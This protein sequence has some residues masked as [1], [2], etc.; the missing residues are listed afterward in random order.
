MDFTEGQKLELLEMRRGAAG[1]GGVLV[2]GGFLLVFLAI[3]TTLT[4]WFGWFVLA[5]GALALLFSA[6]VCFFPGYLC[7]PERRKERR[8]VDSRA[9]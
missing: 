5:C 9:A 8:S 4:W 2:L 1:V 6:A 3:P 7:R